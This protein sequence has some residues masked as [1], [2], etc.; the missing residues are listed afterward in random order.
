M[1]PWKSV[2]CKSM[3]ELR[4]HLCQTSPASKGTRDFL[5]GNYAEMKKG[6]PDFPI[7]VRECSGAEAKI[8]ARYD[9]GVEKSVS[10]QNLDPGAIASKLQDLVKAG[11]GLPRSGE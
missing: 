5:V 11:E 4:I 1:A 6:N 3:Q 8:T 2:L 9:F 7:L 10:I